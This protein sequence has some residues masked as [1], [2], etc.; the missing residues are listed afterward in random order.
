MD[1]RKLAEEFLVHMYLFRKNRPQKRIYDSL[2]GEAFAL[3]S[4]VSSGD[5]TPSEISEDIELSGARVAAIL[6]SLENKGYI[7]RQIDKSDRRR[8]LVTI[9]EAGKIKEMEYRNEIINLTVAML[10]R[11]G[12]K[13]A[14]EYIR[15]TKKLV[16]LSNNNN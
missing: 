12:D 4:I 7:T 9:T 1:Y 8:I 6:N 15:I 3:H 16:D 10:K 2:Q 11:L 5:T 13:D 14:G